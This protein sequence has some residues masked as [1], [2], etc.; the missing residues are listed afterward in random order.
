M[1][2][3]LVRLNDNGS[4]MEAEYPTIEGHKIPEMNGEPDYNAG[5]INRFE[6]NYFALN[7]ARVLALFGAAVI[8]AKEALSLLNSLDASRQSEDVGDDSELEVTDDNVLEVIKANSRLNALLREGP[9]WLKPF[10]DWNTAASE[11]HTKNFGGYLHT[12]VEIIS[13][14]VIQIISDEQLVFYA[15]LAEF[16]VKSHN[17]V[18]FN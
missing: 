5:D 1:S 16:L 11:K 14:E 7:R 18:G 9:E 6:L 10:V 2:N 8:D 4:A 13:N 3:Q 12:A 17:G 15:N